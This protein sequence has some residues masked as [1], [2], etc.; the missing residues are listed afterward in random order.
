MPAIVPLL[1]KEYRN[2]AQRLTA[3]QEELT[4]LAPERLK[5]KVCR[6]STG[7]PNVGCVER[8][9]VCIVHAHTGVNVSRAHLA[10]YD[11][12]SGECGRHQS[13]EMSS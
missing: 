12:V 11:A 10:E 6:V 2:A 4:D 5:E 3:T 7:H 13:I 8:D 9:A 1:E